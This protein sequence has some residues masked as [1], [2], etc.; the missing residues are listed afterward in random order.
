MR[1]YVSSF[2]FVMPPTL[3]ADAAPLKPTVNAMRANGE[4][5]MAG[6][7]PPLADCVLHSSVIGEPNIRNQPTLS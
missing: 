1:R 6:Q 2:A 7:R 4:S 5:V 3:D